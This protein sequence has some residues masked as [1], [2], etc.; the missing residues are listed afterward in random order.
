MIDELQQRVTERGYHLLDAGIPLGCGPMVRFLV[1]LPTDSP[2][3]VMAALG[4]YGNDDEL[5]NRDL[6]AWFRDF[7][8]DHPFVLRGC[9]HDTV[10]IHLEQPLSDPKKWAKRLI[11][12]DSDIWHDDLSRFEVHLKTATRLHFWWD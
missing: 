7:Q 2:F 4:T 6:I 3:A 12:F 11:E 1:L 5:S 8:K 10:D 9:K